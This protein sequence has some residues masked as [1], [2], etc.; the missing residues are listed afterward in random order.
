[1]LCEK[2][3][4]PQ[5]IVWQKQLWRWGRPYRGLDL[6]LDERFSQCL[7][8]ARLSRTPSS[9]MKVYVTFGAIRLCWLDLL[10]RRLRIEGDGSH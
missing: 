9:N 5:R 3:L 2:V 10:T 1:M 6:L 7:Q 8:E 4:G